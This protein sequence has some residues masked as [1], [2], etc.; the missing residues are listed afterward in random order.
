M[1][2]QTHRFDGAGICIYCDRCQFDWCC[3]QGPCDRRAIERFLAVKAIILA[4]LRVM[5]AKDEII[6]DVR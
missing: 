1:R 3:T 2:S 4:E 5:R 6:L